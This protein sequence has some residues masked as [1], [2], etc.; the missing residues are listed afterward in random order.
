MPIIIS[1]L[2]GNKFLFKWDG[3][4]VVQEV[5]TNRAYKIIDENELRIG[6]INEKFLKR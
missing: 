5:Y 2:M 3:S 6:F 4:Y 1:K